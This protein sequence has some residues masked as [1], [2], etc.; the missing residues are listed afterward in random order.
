MALGRLQNEADLKRQVEQWLLNAT[1]LMTPQGVQGLPEALEQIPSKYATDVGD[2]VATTIA[3]THGLDTR[4]VLV[5]VYEAA[6]PY[7]E[8]IP[9]AVE[10]TDGDTVDLTFAAAPA[11]DEFRVV[12]VG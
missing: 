10:H 5:G 4:D 11:T 2:G 6:T 1:G 3:V 7:A 8:V 9:D 12:V